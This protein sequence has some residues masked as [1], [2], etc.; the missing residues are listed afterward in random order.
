ME[1]F[2]EIFGLFVSEMMAKDLCTQIGA[3]LEKEIQ[4]PE[5]LQDVVFIH[6]TNNE[7]KY[8][9]F[10]GKPELDRKEYTTAKLNM[11]SK[12]TEQHTLIIQL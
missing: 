3:H 11:A 2:S 9:E 6:K 10:E 7:H 1:K 5:I 4:F 12:S 8:K